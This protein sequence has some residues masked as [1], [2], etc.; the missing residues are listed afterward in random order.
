[1]DNE[2]FSSAK[3]TEKKNGFNLGKEIFEWFYTILIAFV[4]AFL[5]KAFLF[6]FVIVEGPSMK[7]TLMNGDR[8][9]ITK[10]GYEPQQQDIIVLD[11]A[12]KSRDEYFTSLGIDGSFERAIEYF[13]LPKG[14]KRRY[15]VK[16][17]IAMPGQTVDL[18]DGKVY[19][20][21]EKLDEEYYTGLTVAYDAMIQFPF[22]V[23]EDCIFVMGDNR[24][25]SK[26]SRS[27]SLGE[28]PIEAVEGKCIFRIFPFDSFGVIEH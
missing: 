5:I 24:P 6:D 8:L 18:I 1:M 16:R 21:G 10:L 27:S 15:Y 28:V 19:V 17:V 20:D 14:L 3:E 26:D 23:S 9:I 4:I 2:E 22:T 7:P 13:K 12:Y 25:E 11:S